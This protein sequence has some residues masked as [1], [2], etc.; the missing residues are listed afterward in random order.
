MS[1]ARPGSPAET[2]VWVTRAEPGASRT[3]ARL[4]DMGME[5]VVHPLLTV[6]PLTPPLPDLE[7]FAA[8]A[9]TSTNG[10]AAFAALTPRRDRP[11]F[12]V[13]QTTAQ[14]AQQAGFV[15]IRSADGDLPA[16]ARL[17]AA[18]LSDAVL[19]APQ[20]ETPAGD[21]AMA[22]EAAGARSIAAQP[23]VVYRTVEARLPA[24]PAF[25]AV[26][27]HSPRAAQAF[28]SWLDTNPDPDPARRSHADAVY[29]CISPAAASPLTPLGLR[30]TISER[31]DETTLL[32]TLKAALG[33]R[34]APV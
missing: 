13:G 8:L 22:L 12:A 7:R 19:L 33:K 5:P 9:F 18:E 34:D 6:E 31:P 1:A 17:I 10:V 32:A 11:V 21:L 25:D 16:L 2:R 28:A 26:L 27:F 15:A 23:L 24:P 20:A 29:V 3:A 14:A 4:R 30:P